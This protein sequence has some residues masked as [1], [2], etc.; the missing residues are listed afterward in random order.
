LYSN[1]RYEIYK[2]A[3]AHADEVA[4]GIYT[5]FQEISDLQY[6]LLPNGTNV[7]GIPNQGYAAF[8]DGSYNSIVFNTYRSSAFPTTID[9]SGVKVGDV[10]NF[11]P[12]NN[13][14]VVFSYLIAATPV[15]N[16]ALY[17]ATFSGLIRLSYIS[18]PV[19][20]PGGF[21]I[22]ADFLLSRS[23]RQT[24]F[25]LKDNFGPYLI[26]SGSSPTTLRDVYLSPNQQTGK[27]YRYVPDYQTSFV[28]FKTNLLVGA[29]TVDDTILADTVLF[30]TNSS[31]ILLSK[32]SSALGGSTVW[33]VAS[34]YGNIGF[35]NQKA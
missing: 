6:R 3:W 33:N 14:A 27:A 8:T 1:S 16:P 7:A 21:D 9:F 35:N 20:L 11:S 25:V 22:L 29:P 32:A 26:G 18:D 17:T 4:L 24:P 10:L 19:V 30:N 23:P 2:S 34:T 15:L 31:S 13:R 5:N 12:S 28:S